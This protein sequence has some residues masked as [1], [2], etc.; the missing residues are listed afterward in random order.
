MRWLDGITNSM[1]MSMS[2]LWELVKDR[3]AWHTAA[4]GVAKSQTRLSNWTELVLFINH[5]KTNFQCS[6]LKTWGSIILILILLLSFVGSNLLGVPRRNSWGSFTWLWILGGSDGKE[7]A[8]NAGDPGSILGSGG[9]AGEG[10]GNPLQYSCLENSMD[11]KAWRA[12]YSPWGLKESDMTELLTLS[13]SLHF[14]WLLESKS[15]SQCTF[16][17][18]TLNAKMKFCPDVIRL[19]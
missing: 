18:R 15:S 19:G 9:S 8:C 2:K 13:L 7:S 14:T 11:R 1:D 12:T 10:N 4:H 6:N 3:E 16:R 5:A 17:Y